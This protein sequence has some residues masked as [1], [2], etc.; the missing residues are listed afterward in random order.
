MSRHFGN[1]QWRTKLL[2]CGSVFIST[3]LPMNGQEPRPEQT[4]RPAPPLRAI[5][6]MK[7]EM[8]QSI[9][10]GLGLPAFEFGRLSEKTREWISHHKVKRIRPLYPERFRAKKEG[11]LSETEMVNRIKSRFP[12]RT[13]R[14]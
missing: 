1:I 11:G 2:L 14:A 13:E 10:S 12:G 3:L 4:E 7:G 8:A 6:K 9:E 5:V